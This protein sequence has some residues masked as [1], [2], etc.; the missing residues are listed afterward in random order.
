[1][2]LN[3][4]NKSAYDKSQVGGWRYD[5]LSQGLKVNMPDICAAIGLAQIRIYKDKLLPERKNISKFYDNFFSNF[6]W[7]IIPQSKS[8]DCESS[9]HLYMLRI[10]SFSESKRD[11]MIDF[12]SR[13]GV[14]VN[15]HYIP[16]SMLTLFKEK[17]YDI[18][19]YPITYSLYENEISLPI[20]NGLTIL[21]LEKIT[22]IVSL[23]YEKNAD[24]LIDQIIPKKL[25][26]KL[27]LIKIKIYFNHLFLIVP[28]W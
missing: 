7:A 8:F 24:K 9:Y 1:M 2:S 17:G 5:I 27:I 16:M 6:D 22:N 26:L 4:Q 14:A 20:Y 13:S 18:V 19:N 12:I 15:V 23:A 11:K 21:Q 25:I 3:G 28:F 10:K